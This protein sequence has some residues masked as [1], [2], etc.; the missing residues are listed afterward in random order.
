LALLLA[1]FASERFR[2]AG[3]FRWGSGGVLLGCCWGSAGV[4]LVF[5]KGPLMP[6]NLWQCH[7]LCGIPSAGWCRAILCDCVL[8]R[9]HRVPF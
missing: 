5:R 1:A 6:Q 4:L 3:M 7:G 8:L 9:C 2:G